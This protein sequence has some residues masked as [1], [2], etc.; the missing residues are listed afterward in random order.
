MTMKRIPAT[1]LAA[2]AVF[3]LAV[4]T[5]VAQPGAN[6]ASGYVFPDFW[7]PA[8]AQLKGATAPQQSDAA[9]IGIY[10]TS[11]QSNVVELFPPNPWQ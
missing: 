6:A 8:S 5:A 11:H 9:G 3:S 2:A 7:G 1:L 4:G 10:G